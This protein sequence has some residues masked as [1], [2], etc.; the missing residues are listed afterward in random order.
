MTWTHLIRFESQ[1]QIHYGDAVF[2]EGTDPGDIAKIAKD[3]KLKATLIEG[4]VFSPEVKASGRT[5]QVEKL[6]N[7]LTR[8]QV[9]IIRCIGL[10]YMKHSKNDKNHDW[11]C[12][13]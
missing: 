6:L 3:G 9:P 11:Q 2:P 8:Q 7:P 1:G 13:C 4:D 5:L 12:I 10:N